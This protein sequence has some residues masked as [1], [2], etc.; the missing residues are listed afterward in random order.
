M[1]V[2]ENQCLLS[3]QVDILWCVTVQWSTVKN[4][5]MFDYELFLCGVHV[6]EHNN[7]NISLVNVI[8]VLHG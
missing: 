5:S 6:L 7:I 3:S 1:S 2:I 4:T 8:E